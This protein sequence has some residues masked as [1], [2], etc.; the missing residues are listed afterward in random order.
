[1][2]ITFN[3]IAFPP[4]SAEQNVCTRSQAAREPDPRTFR[5]A[6]Q[7]KRRAITDLPRSPAQSRHGRLRLLTLSARGVRMQVI[8]FLAARGVDGQWPPVGFGAVEW[9]QHL[10]T[11]LPP[12]P[13][14]ALWPRDSCLCSLRVA[15]LRPGHFHSGTPGA[16]GNPRAEIPGA[17]QCSGISS[18]PSCGPSPEP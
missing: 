1:M 9:R 13:V 4:S 5:D 8:C 3:E 11:A 6:L 15:G 2:H 17:R 16:L 10:L 7:C 18:T 12:C 14:R